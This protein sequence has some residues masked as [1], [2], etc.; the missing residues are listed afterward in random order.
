MKSVRYTGKKNVEAFTEFLEHE[1]KSLRE[2]EE[3]NVILLIH[4]KEVR[5]LNNCIYY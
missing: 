5:V 2:K 3:V 4:C 1:L